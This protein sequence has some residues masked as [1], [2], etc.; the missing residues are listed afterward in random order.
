MKEEVKQG[1]G[2]SPKKNQPPF[3]YNTPRDNVMSSSQKQTPEKTD[4]E[5]I[6]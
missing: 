1:S 3:D 4:N 2:A 5:Q 6:N